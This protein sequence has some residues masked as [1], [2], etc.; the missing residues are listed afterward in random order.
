M[1]FFHSLK[2]LRA[3]SSKLRSRTYY[4]FCAWRCHMF[5]KAFASFIALAWCC[6]RCFAVNSF[7]QTGFWCNKLWSIV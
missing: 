7:F 1:N 2:V 4:V 5:Q 3:F 6:A